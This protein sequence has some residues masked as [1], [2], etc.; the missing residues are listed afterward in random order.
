MRG[1]FGGVAGRHWPSVGIAGG[2]P[3]LY[4]DDVQRG[5]PVRCLGNSVVSQGDTRR[6]LN[7][8]G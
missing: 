6:P 2:D 8:R 4:D 7:S 3:R 1:K 5:E